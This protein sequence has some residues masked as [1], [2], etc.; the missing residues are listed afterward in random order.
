MTPSTDEMD[1]ITPEERSALVGYCE[2]CQH[3]TKF[4]IGID[5]EACE[6][7]QGKFSSQSGHQVITQRTFNPLTAKRKST[8]RR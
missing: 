6:Q 3:W 4:T 5:A 8:R 1:R 7:C 2:A